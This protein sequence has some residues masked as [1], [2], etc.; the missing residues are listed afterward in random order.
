MEKEI[1]LREDAEESIFKDKGK[2]KQYNLEGHPQKD[3]KLSDKCKNDDDEV[4]GKKRKWQ[5][6]KRYILCFLVFWGFLLMNCERSCLSVAIVAMSSKRKVKVDGKWV[7]KVTQ[8]FTY[9]FVI[10][11]I[12]F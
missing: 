9:Q 11:Y 8:E 10:K 12:A 7:T 2:D 5:M 1:L 6:P 4:P 3:E